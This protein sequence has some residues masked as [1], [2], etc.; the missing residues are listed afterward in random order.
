MARI[1]H[2]KRNNFVIASLKSPCLFLG[3]DF[4]SNSA[5]FILWIVTRLNGYS[6]TTVKYDGLKIQRGIW[7]LVL[8]GECRRA[9]NAALWLTSSCRCSEMSLFDRTATVCIPLPT[10]P[11]AQCN[12]EE[13]KKDEEAGSKTTR[14]QWIFVPLVITVDV[15]QAADERGIVANEHLN[16]PKTIKINVL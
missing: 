13:E 3:V 4:L 2:I 11:Y 12:E 9:R 1:T 14:D 6:I 5:V 15:L 8:R 16:Q 7:C 10:Q